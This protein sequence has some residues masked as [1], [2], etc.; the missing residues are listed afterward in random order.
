MTDAIPAEATRPAE[1][2]DD[3]HDL[4]VSVVIPCLNEAENIEACVRRARTT[5]DE[6]GLAGEVIVV[7]NGSEDGSGELARRAGA[8]VVDE[9]RRGY[10]SA[11]Q[12]GFAAARGRYIVMGD[13][14]LT[15]DFGDVP[16]FVE[17]LESGA[18]LV[19]GDRLGSAVHP[20][21]MPWLHR[22][23]GNPL[24]TRFYNLLYG[25]GIRDMW[26]GMR[27]LRRDRL[28]ELDLRGL[29]MEFAP[30]MVM[31]ASKLGLDI[32]QFPI[33]YHPRGGE[34]KL[35]TFRD[36]WRGLR[37]LL[38]HSPTALFLVPGAVMLVV[39]LIG[40][41][42]VALD[43]EFFG[44]QWSFHALI[45]AALLTI[46]GAQVITLGVSARA[47]GVYS[48]NEP[49]DRLFEW[50]SRRLS[51]E[52]GLM[53]GIVVFLAGLGIAAVIVGTWLGRG[54]GELSEE[55]LM[56]VGAVLLILGLQTIFSAFFL[57]IL[58]LRREDR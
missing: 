13:A 57:S 47:F 12:A 41:A 36:G 55:R 34:S 8:T 33:E 26:C 4:I 29:G 42:L 16:R 43:L 6:S 2:P 22:R 18:D 37:L 39:G 9:H 54:F 1:A 21:A 10:G 11:Y 48:L 44:R 14:D 49:P 30:E 24:M 40:T 20:G 53:I 23:V 27:G 19:M 52:T 50:A 28:R 46:V 45:A 35:S 3:R 15:Y 51:L 17:E 32:R 5:L 25:T 56:V 58:G 38:V 7:D 31:R